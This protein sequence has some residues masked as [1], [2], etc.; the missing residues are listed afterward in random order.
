MASRWQV[1]ETQRMMYGSGQRYGYG[2]SI[3]NAR[4]APLLNVSYATEGEARR[5]EQLV[6]EALENAADITSFN[7]IF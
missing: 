4:G 7:E 1:G 6:R 3:Q 5:A 2:F